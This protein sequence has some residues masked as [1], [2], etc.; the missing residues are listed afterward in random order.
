M[1]FKLTEEHEMI[2][3]M[4][5]DFAQNEVAPTAAERDEEERFDREIFDKMA[6]LGLTG[7]PWPE[8]YGGI[9]SDYLAYCI[10]IEELSRVCAST[11]VTLSAHTSLAG[12][13]IYKFGTEEQKQKYLR[14]M[15]QGEKIG[16]YG[17]TEPSSGSDAGGMRTTA[18]LV[19]DEYVIS[20]S[21]IFITNG[22]IA[23]TYVVFALTDPESKQKGT[24]AFIIEKDFPGFSVGKKEKK[25][26]IR[27]SPT[28]EI[29]F[30]ECRVPKENLLGKEGE[31]FKIAMMTLDGGRN[32]IAAQAV[33]IAQ[34]ALDAAVDYAK[35]RVQFG[36]PI[37]AQ[38]GIGFKLADMAT[39][40]EAS[41]LLTYQAAWLESVGLPY[42][43]E[44]AM[45]KLFAGDTAM[46]VTTEAV[47]V[48]G[49]YGYTKDYPVER[50]MR[51]AKITQIYE[52]TQ[53]IQKLVISRM[54][55]K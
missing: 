48:F 44:S 20:G 4:V 26:G 5:R 41:R 45:S 49:G 50:Y 54:V 10:A 21:K 55:T 40:V 38:Q 23:D 52:G 35:E 6:E 25:L 12:W 7:I 29:I 43:K 47:Q 24:S 39:G 18:K 46:K 13:P 37:S 27:S 8:E 17:L 16:A 14:P 15:A 42:G 51:D 19:G 34:G 30:D 1:Q 36:K 9:G 22:G 32:G 11:G 2:R 33:G 53:E 31:G 28:T 3:K